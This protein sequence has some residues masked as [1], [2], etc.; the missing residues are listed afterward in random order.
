[1]EFEKKLNDLF[2]FDEF[3]EGQKEIITSILSGK[4][5][6]CVLPTGGGKSLCYQ[7][8][9][10]SSP[11]FSV[12]ISPLISLMKDQVDRLNLTKSQAVFINSSL[13]SVE[14]DSI[15]ERLRFGE[16]KL[17]YVAPER[18]ENPQFLQ[19]I[20]SLRPRYLFVDEAHCIS[21]WGHN[22]RPS[23][24]NIKTFIDS[25]TFQGVSAFTA[26]AT[27]EV[28]K[29]IS[30][31]LGLDE[32]EIFVRGFA[33]DNISIIIEIVK[34][35]K[36]RLVEALQRYKGSAIIYTSS[37]KKAEEVAD[38]L[39]TMKFPSRYYHAGLNSI[40]RKIVQDEFISGI[41]PIIVATNAFG[42]GID[43]PDVRLV[44]HYN[45][46]GTIESYYQEIGR[47][48]R[49][50]KESFAVLLHD[51]ADI[52]T[53]HYFIKTSYP[54]KDTLIKLYDALCES[55]DIEENTLPD[56]QFYINYDAIVE[57]A[58]I[59]IPTIMFYAG[60]KFLEEEGVLRL[61]GTNTSQTRIRCSI[62]TDH[63]KRY[64]KSLPDSLKKEVILYLVKKYGINLFGEEPIVFL[65]DDCASEV[66][67]GK[68]VVEG[69]LRQ[70]S[71]SGIIDY[72]EPIEKN[73]IRFIL[74]RFP[75]RQLAVSF[76]RVTNLY[77]NAL[78]K[79]DQMVD[80]LY[81][82]QC[83]FYY[84]LDYFG[85]G[86][87][88]YACG[89]C[90][91]CL[92]RSIHHDNYGDYITETVLKTVAELQNNKTPKE[93]L[94]HLVGESTVE[95]GYSGF[96][97]FRSSDSSEITHTI[98]HQMGLGNLVLADTGKI[99][100]SEKGAELLRQKGITP[101]KS[102]DEI[103][104][105][106]PLFHKLLDV[107]KKVANRLGQK[108]EMVCAESILK[109]ITK[110]QPTTKPDMFKI[111]GMSDRI[112]N[113]CGEDFLDVL[114]D[115]SKDEGV[116]LPDKPL[117]SK[118]INE[119]LRFVKDG[120]SLQEISDMRHL[121]TTVVSMQIETIIKA[122]PDVSIKTLIAEPVFN[123]VKQLY[124]E[125]I[126]DL[127]QVKRGLTSSISYAEIRIILARLTAG[128]SYT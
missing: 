115:A 78:K 124:D 27:P 36:A 3:R 64:T 76:K 54:T 102:S 5:V 30:T 128:G 113:K 99:L 119:T 18:L 66:G 67:F 96:G 92:N 122:Y 125:G 61:A 62:D 90:D 57:K 11:G 81:A 25:V 65:L 98:R 16:I 39:N 87:K 95:Q 79:L 44:V 42:M 121:T 4:D 114:R 31:L 77:L 82:K 108:P 116:I 101:L 46:P 2:G 85:A 10:L 100:I 22:F 118:S 13:D 70:L 53:Q 91:N 49:D 60:L 56:R 97:V 127:K 83:R 84:I 112:F 106:L 32:P 12:V 80:Y 28:L 89:K 123:V 58:G 26:T 43:K 7:F 110:Q 51:D 24:R 69:E 68:D 88:E 33:R 117:L 20:S 9:A 15:L 38:F 107:R 104:A 34:D 105:N 63:L 37:R 14:I 93:L 120:Y 103:I 75:K 50:G 55:L 21:Q 74:P 48:G 41:T 23:Y 94:Q 45:T 71:A 59:E 47:A 6:I 126:K 109:Q 17:L 1:M 72:I 8:P 19:K 73:A 40:E 35:K 86:N 52:S 111:P 29:D